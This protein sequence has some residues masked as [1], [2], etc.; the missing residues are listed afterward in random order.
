MLSG[1]IGPVGMITAVLARPWLSTLAREESVWRF[2]PQVAGSGILADAGDHLIDALLWTTGQKAQE[3]GAIQSQREPT[4]DLVTSAA[5]RMMDGTPVALGVSGVT[6]G[7]VFSLTYY[8]DD[9]RLTASDQHLEKEKP[10]GSRD[11][12]ALPSA[13]QTI[14]SNFI[15]AILTDSPL[16]CPADEALE[17]VRLLEAIGRSAATGQFV[18]LI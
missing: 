7:A 10:D 13:E 17:T 3:V 4:I 6:P 8:G 11:E 15:A 1:D 18:R 12:I 16:C 5:I 9:G 2:N 14:D